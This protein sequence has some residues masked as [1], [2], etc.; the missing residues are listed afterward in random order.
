MRHTHPLAIAL[1][2]VAGCAQT[3][4]HAGITVITNGP[5]DSGGRQVA[6]VRSALDF[7]T[8][9][10]C[11]LQ[12]L[13]VLGGRCQG[14]VERL[15]QLAD[16]ALTRGQAMEHAPARG[17]AKGMEDGVQPGLMN[18]NHVVEFKRRRAISQPL[19]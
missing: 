19:G 5:S 14:H 9:Q 2:L 15:G 16:G 8:D 18:I 6:G 13:D 3:S 11:A 1:C 4:A 12:R 10:P 7:A 17:V